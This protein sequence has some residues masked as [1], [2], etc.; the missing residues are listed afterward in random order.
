MATGSEQFTFKRHPNIPRV[1]VD[2]QRPVKRDDI[3][4][5][6][7]YPVPFF[8]CRECFWKRTSVRLE[9]TSSHP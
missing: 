9:T 4:D 5:V 2:C 3:V 8:R 1:C 6:R 7:E